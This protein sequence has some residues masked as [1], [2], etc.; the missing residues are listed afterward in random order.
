[1][2]TINEVP[3]ELGG[4]G[5]QL[6]GIE[7]LIENAMQKQHGNLTLNFNFYSGAKIGQQIERTETSNLWMSSDREMEYLQNGIKKEVP[8]ELTKEQMARA[9]ENCQEY[10]W[11]NSAYAVLFCILRDDYKQKDLTMA[12]FERLVELLPYK[13]IRKHTC[14]AGTIANA[15]SDNAI[16]NSPTE[17]WDE[18][19]ASQ[20]IIKLRNA[21]RKELKVI[22]QL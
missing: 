3:E 15:F 2:E 6:R 17:K 5:A 14:P 16:F 7:S 13:I 20:R 19:N 8:I 9:I 4:F 12:T 22:A 18:M 10:I 11:A 1:M 21:L